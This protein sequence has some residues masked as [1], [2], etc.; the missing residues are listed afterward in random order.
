MTLVFNSLLSVWRSG[1]QVDAELSHPLVWRHVRRIVQRRFPDDPSMHLPK[2]PMRRHHYVYGR[3]RYLTDPPILERLGEIHRELATAQAR[4]AGLPDPDGAGSYTH[5]DLSRVLHAD[6]K[7]VTPLFKAKPGN[8]RVDTEI[9]EMVPIRYET[10]ATLHFEGD[11]EAAWGTKSVMVA[12]RSRIGRSILDVDRVPDPGSEAKVDVSCFERLTPHVPGA[13]AI[14]YDTALRGV[15]HQTILRE[16]GFVPVNMGA[17]AETFGS[18]TLKRKIKR[19][20]KT[21]HVEDKEVAQPDGWSVTLRLFSE[22]GAIGLMRPTEAGDLQ[23]TPLVRKRT[24]RMN[25]ESGL[26]RWYNDYRLPEHLGGGQITVRLH[27]DDGD[28]KRKFNRT[29]NVRPIPPSDPDFPRL[30]GRRNDSESLNRSLEDT[31]FLGRAHSLGWRRQQ[32]QMLG[33]ALMVNALT[34]ARHR[35]AEDLLGAA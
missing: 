5:P 28:R 14:V 4:D 21:V 33:W 9:G 11:G 7:V 3:D 19:R 27:Q 23:F 1:R 13:Q 35:A 30:Y 29:E 26:S 16:L 17:A 10:D 18:K 24:H 25:A 12:T 32:V 31:L 2:Q 20:E 6:G 34:M 15:H 8:F 22:A